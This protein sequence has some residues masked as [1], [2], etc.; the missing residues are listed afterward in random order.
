MYKGWMSEGKFPGQQLISLAPSNC[1]RPFREKTIL[2]HRGPH[3][4]LILSRSPFEGSQGYGS[5]RCLK[6]QPPATFSPILYVFY[7]PIAK[8]AEQ[9]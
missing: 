4:M 7:S 2:V 5:K 3:H 1:H 9:R 8:P 6:N